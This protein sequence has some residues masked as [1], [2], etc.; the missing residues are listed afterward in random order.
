VGWLGSRAGEG[1][2][3]FQDNIGNSNEEISNKNKHK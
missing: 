3:D 1:I 2:E